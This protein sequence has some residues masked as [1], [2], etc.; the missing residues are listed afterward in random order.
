LAFHYIGLLRVGERGQKLFKIDTGGHMEA[1]SV[2][3]LVAYESGSHAWQ[4][5]QAK[6]N[7]LLCLIRVLA[8]T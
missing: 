4:E 7:D 8:S 3:R 5:R 1:G 6:E 2:D